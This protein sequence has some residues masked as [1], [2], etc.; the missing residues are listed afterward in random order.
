MNSLCCFNGSNYS[1]LYVKLPFSCSDLQ[2]SDNFIISHRI[3]EKPP[4]YSKQQVF[5]Y[6]YTLITY[7]LLRY[8]I[9]NFYCK[10]YYKKFARLLLS[11]LIKHPTNLAINIQ[12]I[13][14]LC[15]KPTNL[16]FDYILHNTTKNSFIPHSFT[17]INRLTSK[18]D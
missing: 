3:V 18:V 15:V 6:L 16:L 5:V 12:H 7:T 8:S 9:N 13:Y 17:L 2:I 4:Y 14:H 10:T 11:L 1:I